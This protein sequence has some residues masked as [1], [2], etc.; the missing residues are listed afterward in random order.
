MSNLTALPSLSKS[1]DILEHEAQAERDRVKEFENFLSIVAPQ[2]RKSHISFGVT[3]ERHS[4]GTNF[5]L[6]IDGAET[7]D[8]LMSRA[9]ALWDKLEYRFGA[10]GE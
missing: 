8:E 6:R 4:K 7:E 10:K 1:E 9:V 5:S 2:Q 3:V